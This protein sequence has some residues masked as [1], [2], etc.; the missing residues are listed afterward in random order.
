MKRVFIY[1]ALA[2]VG[3]LWGQYGK[4]QEMLKPFRNSIEKAVLHNKSIQNAL[5]ENQKVALDREEVKGKFL[6]NVSLNALYGYVNTGVDVDLPTQQLPI[7]GINLFE[8]TTKGNLS[9][10]QSYPALQLL[11]LSSAGYRLPTVRKP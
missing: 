3:I 1:P 11:R 5:L 9:T 10:Q 6:P 4:A 8:G 7:T 2:L